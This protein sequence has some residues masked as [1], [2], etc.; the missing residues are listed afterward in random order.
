MHADER[1]PAS[2]TGLL[3]V[4]ADLAALSIGLWRPGDVPLAGC[5]WA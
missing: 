5:T 3:D 2:G 1:I 4:G